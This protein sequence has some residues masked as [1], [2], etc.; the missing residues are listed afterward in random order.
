LKGFAQ[1]SAIT[2]SWGSAQWAFE[3]VGPVPAKPTA[4]PDLVVT[5]IVWNPAK[6]SVGQAVTFSATIKNQGEGASPAG[7]VH[8]VAFAVGGNAVTWS[9]GYTSSLA[10]GAAVSVTANA[11]V[12][13]PT[14]AMAAATQV[15][16]A[17]VNEQNLIAES[18]TANNSF[19]KVL[20]NASFGAS[21]P[22]TSYEAEA[23][24]Y[25]GTLIAGSRTW[26]A[27]SSEASGRAAVQLSTAGQYVQ[28]NLT[29]QARGLVLRYS[30]PNTSNSA[31]YNTGLSLYV[32]GVRKP[33]LVLTNKFSWL[34]GQYGTEGGEIRWSKNPAATPA[35]P[36]RFFDEVAVVLDA[37]YP[38]GTS[39]KLVRETSNLNFAS[40]K[41]VTLD[42]L[43]AEPIPTA[44]AK[45]SNYRSIADFGA[46]PNDRV[47]DTSALNQAIAAVKASGGSAVGVWIPVGTFTFNN[48]V[49]GPG[50]NGRGT[51]IYLDP[52]VS[53]KGAG[54]WYSVLDG[55]FAGIYA[56]GG[57]V[58]I[59]DF[60]IQAQDVIRDDANGLSGIEG[61]L[62]NSTVRNVWIEHAKVGLWATQS[63]S[64][65]G[66]VERATITGNRLRNVWADGLNLHYGTS[67]SVVSNNN[68]RN[69]GDDGM[70][71]WS[72]THLDTGNTFEFNTVQLPG[73]ANG[74]AIYG[75][76]NNSVLSNL[77]A[78]TI[79]NGAGISFGTNFNPPALTGTLN[80]ARNKLVRTGSYHHDYQYN[81][82]ALWGLFV[83]SSGLLKN[84][85]I[86][87]TDNQ[88]QDSTYAGILIEEPATGAAMTFSGNQTTTAG[89]Y[90]VE[91]R[92]TAAGTATFTGNTVTG[93]ALGNVKN[94][95]TAFTI[96]SGN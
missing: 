2:P 1:C 58:T 85:T 21:L 86:T 17:T 78:D 46:L 62:T 57:E 43:E 95:S 37:A 69:S 8:K 60:K 30:I 90:G 22:Y 42:F 87:V 73:L 54:V 63:F 25:Q 27:L 47:D 28:F 92:G 53:L 45:P 6:P 96:V 74:I 50:Y 4:K 77:V 89:T 72:D 91:I 49:A 84:P 29:A 70:A 3:Y 18:N 36:H 15:V 41:T 56:K 68:I 39:I 44:L 81:I 24:A 16:S 5:D 32:N 55:A 12:A 40:T 48:G 76:Q 88:I 38:A 19:S 66:T 52:G 23:A 79:D 65:A 9:D 10:P 71:M 35:N 64:Q 67:N 75:G 93:A 33:D 14:W 13:G 82:G 51:R 20:S 7:V 31:A 26:G 11:G 94:N 59:A 34:Y 83:N 61:N 80:I